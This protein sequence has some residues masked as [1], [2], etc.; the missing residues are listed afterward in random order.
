M[1]PIAP[2]AGFGQRLARRLTATL[3]VVDL[4]CGAGGTSEGV[5]Q[6]CGVAPVLVINH[7]EHAIACHAA[8]YRATVQ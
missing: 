8:N 2:L 5:E 4:F 7:D 1:R 6:A 3:C